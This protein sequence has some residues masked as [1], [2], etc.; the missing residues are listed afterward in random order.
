[1]AEEGEGELE[2]ELA[3]VTECHAKDRYKWLVNSDHNSTYESHNS[4]WSIQV[5]IVL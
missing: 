1:M 3:E 2:M 4:L 5:A